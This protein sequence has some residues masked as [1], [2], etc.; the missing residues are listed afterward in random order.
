MLFCPNVPPPATPGRSNIRSGPGCCLLP[1]PGHE[2]LGSPK[3]LSADYLTRLLRSLIVAARWFAPPPCRRAFDTP[4]GRS[5][6]SSRLESATGRSGAYPGRPFTC[7]NS[8]SYRTHH[9]ED[10]IRLRKLKNSGRLR[11]SPPTTLNFLLINL[12]R[13]AFSRNSRK[14]QEFVNHCQPSTFTTRNEFFD[15]SA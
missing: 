14:T 9:A 11:N 2:R 10:G 8:A 15:I 4:L 1:S 12:S 5:D 7:K 13:K 6:F 3:H